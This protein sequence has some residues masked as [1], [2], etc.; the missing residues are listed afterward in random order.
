MLVKPGLQVS[1]NFSRAAC[2]L[3]SSCCGRRMS[4][5]FSGGQR[6]MLMGEQ[7]VAAPVLQ[8][9][10]YI[11]AGLGILKQMGFPS[12]TASFGENNAI[13]SIQEG[14]TAHQHWGVHVKMKQASC[15]N[16]PKPICNVSPVLAPSPSQS[17]FI[18]KYNDWANI[19]ISLPAGLS[20]YFWKHLNLLEKL[21]IFNAVG[22]TVF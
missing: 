11:Q 6:K 10:I 21:I 4:K 20:I 1:P 3:T 2:V 19:E 16:N 8:S 22:D 12:M 7:L 14:G 17:N 9:W 15:R 18:N 5:G 13:N